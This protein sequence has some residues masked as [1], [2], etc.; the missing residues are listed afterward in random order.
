M[1]DLNRNLYDRP[2]AH[3][4]PPGGSEFYP[5]TTRILT[6]SEEEEYEEEALQSAILYWRPETERRRQTIDDLN[7]YQFAKAKLAKFTNELD[8]LL[9]KKKNN[10]EPNLLISEK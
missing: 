7:S 6:M 10:L 4:S 1:A 5:D 9:S 8:Q 3:F 2:P